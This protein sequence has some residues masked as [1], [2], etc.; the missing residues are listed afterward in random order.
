MMLRLTDTRPPGS[1]P[2]RRSPIG[3]TLGLTLIEL[4]IVLAVIA[5]LASLLL[6]TLS[7][8]S[9]KAQTTTC[10]N[11]L[12]QLQLGYL[13]Y[14]HDNDD[15]FPFNEVSDAD[16]VQ[17]SL[18]GWVLGNAKLDTND[19]NIIA[20]AIFRYVNSPAVY[21]CPADK[22]LRTDGSGQ[23]RF[24][25][26]ALLAWLNARASTY[27]LQ[28]EAAEFTPLKAKLSALGSISSS[29][30]WAFI[31]EHQQAIDD[32]VF[33]MGSLDDPKWN[34]D[35]WELPTDRHNQGANLS[36]LDGHAEY[37]HWKFPKKFKRYQQRATA[38]IEDLRWLQRKL[39][40]D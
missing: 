5:I 14:V 37:K 12:K 9:M 16:L 40:Y 19:S 31:D 13:N 36:F 38:D 30:C 17:R 1:Q 28:T 6:P 35:W 24:R 23:Q 4:L 33:V 3:V 21:S 18:K 20:G 2:R 27:G 25:S 32:G 8:A 11:N 29:V 34:S 7:Q 15:W 26:Y 22:S 39:P 10:R